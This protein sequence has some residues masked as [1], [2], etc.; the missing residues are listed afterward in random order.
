[1]GTQLGDGLVLHF[2]LNDQG[3][4]DHA[5]SNRTYKEKKRNIKLT[6]NVSNKIYSDYAERETH[7]CQNSMLKRHFVA[8]SGGVTATASV[9][10]LGSAFHS[11]PGIV[12]GINENL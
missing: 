5:T 6:V 2:I 8:A 9:T 10:E 3:P 1:M 11:G 12:R 7:A 4:S